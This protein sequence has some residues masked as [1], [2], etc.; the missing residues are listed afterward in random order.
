MVTIEQYERWKDFALRTARTCFKHRRN[1]T[2]RQI[3]ANVQ[4]FFDGREFYDLEELK[5]FVDWDNCEPYPPDSL[6][7]HKSYRCPCR[8]CSRG[9]NKADCPYNCE[10]GK[11][12]DYA[13]ETCVSDIC[14]ESAE[15]WNPYYWSCKDSE[16]ERRDEQFC[17]PVR[18][19][20]R[21]GMD[22]AVHPSMGVVGFTAGDLRR[23]YPEGVPDW[24][25]GGKDH[26]WSY[27]LKD[28]INGRF[29][30]MKDETRLLL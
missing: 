23:M 6:R 9:E 11:I 3:E 21:A 28:Q 1:P 7:Y 18:C 26:R 13:E 5:S 2:W 27:W 15:S 4:G 14:A 12:F 19:C 30:E 16:Y 24:I 10:D 29:E 17:G 8:H 25:T 20:I 22:M